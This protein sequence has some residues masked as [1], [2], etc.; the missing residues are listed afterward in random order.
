M[1]KDPVTVG[2][3]MGLAIGSQVSK[4]VLL[5]Y[6]RGHFGVSGPKT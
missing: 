1:P 4:D 3:K 2:Y 6:L 5:I